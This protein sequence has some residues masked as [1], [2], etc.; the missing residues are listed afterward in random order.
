MNI[1]S[2]VKAGGTSVQ[3]NQA[4][5]VSATALKSLPVSTNIRGGGKGSTP[6]ES[7]AK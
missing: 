6:A 2:N 4:V 5:R 3:H 1:K 7:E